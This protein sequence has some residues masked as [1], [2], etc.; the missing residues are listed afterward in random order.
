ME[1]SEHIFL[2]GEGAE[3]FAISKGFET[4]END[5]FITERRLNSVKNA[6]KRDSIQDNKFGTVGCVAQDCERAHK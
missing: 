3:D 4:V 1:E 5:S 2:S 6:K